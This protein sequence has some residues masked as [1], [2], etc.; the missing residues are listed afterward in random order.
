MLSGTAL[1]LDVAALRCRLIE[2]M[3]GRLDQTC[4]FQLAEEVPG[5]D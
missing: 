4:R 2:N 3:V 1:T 5:T